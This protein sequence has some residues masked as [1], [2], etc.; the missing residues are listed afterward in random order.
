MVEQLST[1]GTGLTVMV[2]IFAMTWGFAFPAYIRFPDKETPDFFP[3]FQVFNAWS[4]VFV[5][6]FLGMSS[7]RFRAG[8]LGNGS[9]K[10]SPLFKY[11]VSS[12]RRKRHAMAFGAFFG[13]DGNLSGLSSRAMSSESLPSGPD[14]L[15]EDIEAGNDEDYDS[16]DSLDN[17]EVESSNDE[18]KGKEESSSSSDSEEDESDSGSAKDV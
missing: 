17:D 2:M 14:S 16:A 10:G 9:L 8:L 18:K 5:M 12:K 6:A 11:M 3:I 4:G 15:D 7:S 1:Q 13:G